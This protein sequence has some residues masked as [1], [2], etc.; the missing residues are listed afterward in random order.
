MLAHRNVL[1]GINK[2]FGKIQR[3]GEKADD[4][5]RRDPKGKR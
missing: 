1:L 3:V 2:T 4:E 5:F